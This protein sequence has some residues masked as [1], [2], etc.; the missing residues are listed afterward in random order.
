MATKSN[1]K[2]STNRVILLLIGLLLFNLVVA[3]IWFVKS[4]YLREKIRLVLESQLQHRLDHSVQVGKVRGNI[5][6]DLSIQDI[7]I[8]TNIAKEDDL[9]ATK[10]IQLKYHLW[11]FLFGRFLVKELKVIDP[12]IH[13]TVARDGRLILPQLRV[14]EPST[15]S[16]IQNFATVALASRS[17]V[18]DVRVEDG[19][20][21]IVDPRRNL[22]FGVTGIQ[23]SVKGP[24]DRWDHQGN[25][26]VQDGRIIINGVA[27]KI[28]SIETQFDLSQTAGQ[29]RQLQLALGNSKV[30]ISGQANVP[31]L[32]TGLDKSPTTFQAKI[33]VDLDFRD[34][35][36]FFPDHS[37][38]IEGVAEVRL[39]THGSVEGITGQL[40]IRLPFAKLNQL[41]IEEFT[42][43]ARFSESHL[44]LREISGKMAGGTLNGRVEIEKKHTQS[45][46]RYNG[47]IE[48]LKA[49]SEQFFPAIYDLTRIVVGTGEVDTHVSFEGD[50]LDLADCRIDGQ[51]T[52]TDAKLNQ[53]PISVSV[54]NWT[55]DQDQLNATANLDKA[56]IL[57]S[58]SAGLTEK[59]ELD[60][61]IQQI[62]MGKLSQ[63][64]D[65]PD[66]SGIGQLNGT[67]VGQ[68]INGRLQVPKAHLFKVPIGV[69]TTDFNYQSGVVTIQPLTLVKNQ[70]VLTIIGTAKTSGNVPLDL[71]LKIDPFYIQDYIRL[72]GADYPVEGLAKGHLYL[73]G[74]LTAL[75]GR[76]KF[77][78]TQGK[79]WDLTFEPLTLPMIIDDYL[80]QVE[81]FELFARKQRGVMEFEIDPQLNYSLD[82]KTDSISLQQVAYAKN[83]PDF[84]IDCQMVVTA[85]GKG[86]AS[87]PHIDI[88]ADLTNIHYQIP[89][90]SHIDLPNATITGVYSD[91]RLDLEGIGFDTS[92][93]LLGTVQAVAGTP[94]QLLIRGKQMNISPILQV[95]NP[96]IGSYFQGV[97]EGEMTLNGQLED[98]STVK[99]SMEL[100]YLSLTPSFSSAFLGAPNIDNRTSL[101]QLINQGSVRIHYGPIH[102]PSDKGWSIERLCLLGA[103][104]TETTFLVAD[105]HIR[106]RKNNQINESISVHDFASG[107]MSASYFTR[108]FDFPPVL[109]GQINYR[110]SSNKSFDDL[111]VDWSTPELDLSLSM[112]Q[113]NQRNEKIELRLDRSLGQLKFDKERITLGKTDLLINEN[114]VNLWGQL[115]LNQSLPEIVISTDI[116]E[117]PKDQNKISLQCNDFDLSKLDLSSFWPTAQYLTGM[118]DLSAQLSGGLEHP[119]LSGSIGLHQ[120]HL[121]LNTLP[122]PIDNLTARLQ[123]SGQFPSFKQPTD[124]HQISNIDIHLIKSEWETDILNM[125]DHYKATGNMRLILDHSE[126]VTQLGKWQLNLNGHKVELRP[127]FQQYLLH[128]RNEPANGIVTFTSQ[129]EGQGLILNSAAISCPTLSINIGHTPFYA[130][131]PIHLRYTNNILYAD[132]FSFSTQTVSNHETVLKISGQLVPTQLVN[133]ST[134]AKPLLLELNQIPLS[135]VYSLVSPLMPSLGL[136][137]DNQSSQKQLLSGRLTITQSLESPHINSIWQVDFPLT[138]LAGRM[139]YH[140]DLFHADLQLQTGQSNAEVLQLS[141][142]CPVH[143]SLLPSSEKQG[144]KFLDEP[145]AFTLK[146]ETIN[147]GKFSNF[148]RQT[149][150]LKYPH[151]NTSIWP[152]E[153]SGQMEIDF[154]LLGVATAPYMQGNLKW[155][156]GSLNFLDLPLSKIKA[157]VN[158]SPTGLIVP[159][160]KFNIG[161]SH[162]EAKTK[163]EI[164]HLQPKKL[165]VEDFKF[166][167]AEVSDFIILS[168]AWKNYVN[169]SGGAT[170]SRFSELVSGQLT[171]RFGCIIPL[172]DNSL[173]AIA[174]NPTF[175]LTIEKLGLQIRQI[176][177]LD[178]KID[179]NR[180]QEYNQS[181]DDYWVK[182]L[183][184][185]QPLR[186]DLNRQQLTLDPFILVSDARTLLT[187]KATELDELQ[188][189]G[190]GNWHVSDQFDFNFLMSNINLQTLIQLLDLDRKIP[191]SLSISGQ[192]N[193]NFHI[194]GTLK[195]PQLKLSY[196]QAKTPIRINQAEVD[197]FDGEV[198]FDGK[199]LFIGQPDQ[200][201]RVKI[202]QNQLFFDLE[203]DDVKRVDQRQISGRLDL[204]AKDLGLLPL[205][206]SQFGYASGKGNLNLTLGGRLSTPK[207]K[208]IA[209]FQQVRVNL[210]DQ[211][212]NI[213]QTNINL[214][215]TDQGVVIREFQGQLNDGTYN[216][217][218][219][220]KS[221]WSPLVNQITTDLN[222]QLQLDNGCSF[223]QPNL[224]YIRLN[225]ADLLLSGQTTSTS[226]SPL[227]WEPLT[228]N[229]Q[230]SLIFSQGQYEQR[231]EDLVTIWSDT[232]SDLALRQFVSEFPFW[233]NL[234]L[235]LEISAPENIK[236]TS[237]FGDVEI[238]TAI[239]GQLIGPIWQPIL[240]GRVDLLQGEFSLFAIDQPFKILSGSYIE[241][242]G[243]QF[244][245]NPKYTILSETTQPIRNVDLV[246]VDGQ[247]RNRDLVVRANLNGY[248]NEKHNPVLSAEVLEKE[249]GEE[250]RLDQKQILSILT[251]GM[252]DPS[253]LQTATFG[254]TDTI[255]RTQDQLSPMVSSF[256]LQQGQRYF[257]GRIARL[258]GFRQTRL[259]LNPNE[260]ESSRFLLTKEISNRLALTYS[261]TF[262]LHTEPRIEIEYEL[263]KNFAI[264]G[265]RDQGKFGVDL[266]VEKRF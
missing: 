144:W 59:R 28:D 117:F 29:L 82:F 154:Y 240:N 38:Q 89:E 108:F 52:Y 169:N 250:Y 16:Q 152:S 179:D 185:V 62:Q 203:I 55:I 133:K 96:H 207:L 112:R 68:R 164:D 187:P 206:L 134:I 184:N 53:I 196:H 186:F 61:S 193:T 119:N 160:F 201:V 22:Q 167:T 57:L 149:I 235:N 66:L 266:K 205:L 98:L 1:Y 159:T 210:P 50:S 129:L 178:T 87:Y 161:N 231:W 200:P 78:I 162:Y 248:L 126:G 151:L 214:A 260:F 51:L 256:V 25:L 54:L 180:L 72:V 124:R 3:G 148:M 75:D 220:V 183:T 91:H 258:M 45:S 222:V 102:T 209:K 147:M 229:L 99:L 241:N 76:G 243:G 67:V 97:A 251:L 227:D 43:Y 265:E 100:S 44:L 13:L 246:T 228:G 216:L 242:N 86:N 146:G 157:T 63:I 84:P 30:S 143:L 223:Q 19:S 21:K 198:F 24:L 255:L 249:V 190:S 158:T 247:I 42:T 48:L 128:S 34:L 123:V 46:V 106:P 259:V 238:E 139:N 224:Y 254:S 252:I 14:I 188:I 31:K 47:R 174:T 58:G 93:R 173:N 264:K 170:I 194:G 4:D 234:K 131:E 6:T 219:W 5:L 101:R 27:A 189:T 153:V 35:I 10:E 165:I 245:F 137:F 130:Q 65:I 261:S 120:V 107:K 225:R 11:G 232:S 166:E 150:G 95:I 104:E 88:Q 138:K 197:T 177:S 172:M 191:E 121:N 230:G 81:N 208:G 109:S 85:I 212:L 239:N 113:I 145:M 211:R 215:F 12:K 237:E 156:N 122:I 41:T 199:H 74:S 103:K 263:G 37:H 155:I 114:L 233:Q 17:K 18:A 69:L 127:Y 70:S 39:E 195:N 218:G 2:F 175:D 118:V 236:L 111:I 244:V 73:N 64:L 192:V 83:I 141:G 23:L 136:N 60:L 49:K 40:G 116:S 182:N 105:K 115:M 257:G 142:Y 26:A 80:V 163:I 135:A 204:Q 77:E 92:C 213:E 15:D 132:N 90:Y 217:E 110:L 8:K 36:H 168:S 71:I 94:Y 9:L 181:E 7:V 171:G 221:E 33:D 253:T 140:D 56:Q 176:Q 79:A 262:Q 32:K 226:Q 125:G 202:D 20:I